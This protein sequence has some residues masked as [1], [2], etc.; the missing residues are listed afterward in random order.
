MPKVTIKE[1]SSGKFVQ[2][3]GKIV[4]PVD[5]TLYDTGDSVDAQFCKGTIIY[6]IGKDDSCKRGEYKEAWFDTGVDSNLYNENNLNEVEQGYRKLLS[7]YPVLYENGKF[8]FTNVRTEHTKLVDD[9]NTQLH[10]AF[11]NLLSEDNEQILNEED[12]SS[13]DDF[14]KNPDS[15]EE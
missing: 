4:R 13:L 15:E 3:D 5:S 10:E 12:M 9:D 14:I 2:T 8:S 1:D 11:R 7:D 6:G